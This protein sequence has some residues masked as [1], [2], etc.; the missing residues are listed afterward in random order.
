MDRI[1]PGGRQAMAVDEYTNLSGSGAGQVLLAVDPQRFA[2]IAA[3]RPDWAGGRPLRSLTAALDPPARRRSCSAETRYGSG[4]PPP[5]SGRGGTLVLD[6]YEQGVGA[7]GQ[8]PLYLGPVSGS[9]TATAQLTGCPCLLADLTYSAPSPSGAVI[10]PRSVTG[11]ITVAAI[12]VRSGH[13]QW[14]PGRRRAHRAPADGGPAAPGAEAPSSPVPGPGLVLQVP[15][16]GESQ[17]GPR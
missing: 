16:R 5:R 7:V 3:W 11:S 13:G 15:A 6:V 8:T 17:R 12:D 4:S 2:R 10:S 1:D 14:T 9:R